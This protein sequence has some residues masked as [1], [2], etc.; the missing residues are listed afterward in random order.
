M[1]FDEAKVDHY[2]VNFSL[3]VY[4]YGELAWHDNIAELALRLDNALQS[5]TGDIADANENAADLVAAERATTNNQVSNLQ[6]QINDLDGDLS[7]AL[8]A[9]QA[10]VDAQLAAQDAQIQAADD[11]ITA[12]LAAMS[13]QIARSNSF[14][15]HAH[16]FE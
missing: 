15:V 3:P 9:L 6:Q 12:R 10:S 16:A 5:I 1:A 7:Q 4:R 8:A 13:G 11:E 14:F 2:T